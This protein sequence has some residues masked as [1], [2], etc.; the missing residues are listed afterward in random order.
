MEA[1]GFSKTVRRTF[2]DTPY[3]VSVTGDSESLK[4]EVE[5]AEDGKRWR[6]KF[7]ASFIEEITQRTGNAKKFDI[8]VR[9]MLSALAQ[10]S[11]SVYLD[12]LTARDLEMLR[13]HANPQGPPTTTSAAAQSDKRYL[14]LTYCA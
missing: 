11:D 6:A 2:H 8:F 9:M 14:I 4:I 1:L 12:V 13:R 7:A 3:V 5:H 10:E